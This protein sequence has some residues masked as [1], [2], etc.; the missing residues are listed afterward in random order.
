MREDAV[1][2][3]EVGVCTCMKVAGARCTCTFVHYGIHVLW[4][5][6]IVWKIAAWVTRLWSTVSWWIWTARTADNNDNYNKDNEIDNSN[7]HALLY[8]ALIITNL[9]VYSRKELAS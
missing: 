4:S 8:A 2:Q 1:A 5:A 3:L 9:L 6:V 7:H